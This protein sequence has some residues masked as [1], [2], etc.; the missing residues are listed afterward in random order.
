MQKKSSRGIFKGLALM[1][2]LSASGCGSASGDV[3]VLVT[4]KPSEKENSAGDTEGRETADAS[5]EDSTVVEPDS[6][7]EKRML[8]DQRRAADILQQTVCEKKGEPAVWAAIYA[9]RL[10]IRH[11]RECAARALIRGVASDDVLVRALSW[12][13]LASMKTIPLPAR[14]SGSEADPVVQVYQAIALGVRGDVPGG[15]RRALSLPR[16]EPEGPSPR[17]ETDRR[18]G[19]LKAL[20]LPFD[21]GPLALAISFVESRQE[22]WVE[23]DERGRPHW[24]AERLRQELVSAITDDPSAKER[25]TEAAALKN[26]SRFTEVSDRLDNLLTTRPPEILRSIAVSGSDSLRVQALRAIAVVA[27]NPAAGDFGAA[28]AAMTSTS[29]LLRIEGARTYLLLF[30]RLR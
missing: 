27:S 3:K 14:K 25:L 29:P 16:G 20:S 17:T 8:A 18:T 2:C 12:R 13:R 22:E 6:S 19:H 1:T 24:S 28:A 26:K 7:L 23:K 30:L 11:N 15:F 10:G 4:T 21:E 9:L 5:S